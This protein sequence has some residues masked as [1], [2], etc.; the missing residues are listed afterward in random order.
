MNNLLKSC[1]LA[2][3]ISAFLFGSSLL[4]K[5]PPS[6]IVVWPP[7]GDP[8]VRFTLGKLKELSSVG[9]LHSYLIETTAE[10]LWNKPIGSAV[11]NLY[12]FDKAKVRI[13]EGWISLSNVAP[14]Q[15]VKLASICWNS[16]K[17]ASVPA[18][19]PWKSGRMT[20]PAAA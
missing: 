10:N 11:F 2:S 7:S 17:K 1:A 16:A 9:N 4:A 19:S 5:E 3:T 15:T 14:G 8:L 18:I 13:G 20:R 6:Q 12:L